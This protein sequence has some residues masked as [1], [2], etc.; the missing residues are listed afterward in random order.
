MNDIS[1]ILRKRSPIT[2]RRKSRM[3]TRECRTLPNFSPN[4]FVSVGS[5]SADQPL[6]LDFSQ[7]VAGT[8]ELQPCIEDIRLE[9]DRLRR[10]EQLLRDQSVAQSIAPSDTLP[11][12]FVA[13]P[14]NQTVLVLVLFPVLLK[15]HTKYRRSGTRSRFTA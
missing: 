10:E 2:N 3:S 13:V 1:S 4:C 15:N 14:A 7:S 6:S 5:Y 8:D 11:F 9:I 12:S